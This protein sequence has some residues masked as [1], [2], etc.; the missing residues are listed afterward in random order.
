MTQK[1]Y[2]LFLYL[3]ENVNLPVTREQL[4][5]NVWGFDF[6]GELR[7]V[8]DLVKRLRKKLKDHNSEVE[9]STVWGYGYKI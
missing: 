7:V 1:E 8:D 5:E 6:E 4:V 2:E 3:A 9:I